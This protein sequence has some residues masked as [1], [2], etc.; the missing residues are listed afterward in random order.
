MVVRTVSE[1]EKPIALELGGLM[2][3]DLRAIS[4]WASGIDHIGEVWLYGSRARGDHRVDS[5]IDLAI[6]TIGCSKQE[7]FT[8]YIAHKSSWPP[9][10]VRHR[11]DLN[12][13]EHEVLADENDDGHDEIVGPAV[14]RDGIKLYTRDR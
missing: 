8:S 12:W 10:A 7:R 14:R 3:A 11:V 6:V 2:S 13:F 4:E 5:D 9:L 1:Q